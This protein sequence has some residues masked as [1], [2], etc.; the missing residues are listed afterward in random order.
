MLASKPIR[1]LAASIIILLAACSLTPSAR[2]HCPQYANGYSEQKPCWLVNKPEA[3]IVLSASKSYQGWQATLDKLVD[4]AKLEFASVR[5]GDQVI[6]S[7]EVNSTIIVSGADDVN[8]RISYKRTSVVNSPSE[9]LLV[10]AE[11]RD[12]YFV[13]S[14]ERAWVWVVEIE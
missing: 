2:Q 5:Y 3:G 8:E 12:Y 13:P 9:Q 10:R 14:V 1:L 6:L 11:L 7:S 4:T